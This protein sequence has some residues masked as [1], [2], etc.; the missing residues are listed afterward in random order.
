MFPSGI[1]TILFFSLSST[2]VHMLT[3]VHTCLVLNQFGDQRTTTALD[4]LFFFSLFFR[5]TCAYLLVSLS[6]YETVGY[7]SCHEGIFLFFFFFFF[8]FKDLTL[9]KF[10]CLNL[11][12]TYLRLACKKPRELHQIQFNLIFYMPDTELSVATRVAAL[13]YM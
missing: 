7:R 9:V 10:I 2:P 8:F 6:V 3:C 4:F 1:C 12:E 13:F 5:Y 11:Q